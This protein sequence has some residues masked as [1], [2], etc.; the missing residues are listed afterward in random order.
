M[1]ALAVVPTVSRLLAVA[2]GTA[3]LAEI[4]TPQGMK[5]LATAGAEESGTVPSASPALDH[6][7]LCGLSSVPL[8]PPPV[9]AALPLLAPAAAMPPLFGA[10]PRPLFAWA[11]A[12]PRGPPVSA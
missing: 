11:A 7:A 8:A 2:Q 12:R 3:S 4:C 9:A 6:C 1:L 10:A 5:R